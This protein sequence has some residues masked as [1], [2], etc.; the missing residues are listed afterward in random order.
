MLEKIISGGQ[1]GADRAGL[2]VAIN[3]GF[4]CCG[5]C[6][7]GRKAEDGEIPAKYPLQETKSSDYR[8]R[9]EQNVKDSDGTV[10]FTFGEV[11]GGSAL[12]IKFAKKHKKPFLSIDLSNEDIAL[13]SKRVLDWIKQENIRILNLAGSRESKSPGIYVKVCNIL[14]TVLSKKGK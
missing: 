3:A 8:V 2:D 11:T 12:T 9:T 5:W 10:I 13:L 7:K 4:P 1:T 14:A 6:P